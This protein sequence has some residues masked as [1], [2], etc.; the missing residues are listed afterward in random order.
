MHSES[1]VNIHEICGLC[2][3]SIMREAM[4]RRSLDNLTVVMIG[5]Y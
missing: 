5:K 3:E 1:D 4:N 2:V